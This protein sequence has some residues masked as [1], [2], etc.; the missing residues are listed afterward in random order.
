[1]TKTLETQ[2]NIAAPA[3]TVWAVLDNIAA[4]GAWNSLV[5]ELAGQ[6]MVGRQ[7]TGTLTREGLPTVPLKPTITAVVAAREFRWLS[8]RPVP[9]EF[10]AEHYFLLEPNPDGT[11]TLHHN[12][13]FAG[14]FLAVVWDGINGLGRVAYEKMNAEM[15]ARAEAFAN[16]QPAL[17]PAVD[18]P[19]PES[20]DRLQGATLRCACATDPVEVSLGAGTSHNHL[21]GCSKCWRPDGAL[22]AQIA[23][24]PAGKATVTAHGDKLAPVDPNQKIVRHACNSCGTHMIGRVSDPDHHFFGLDFVHPELAVNRTAAAPEF[25]GFV[26]S[27]IESGTDPA[28]MVAIRKQLSAR[29]LPAYDGFSPEMMDVIAWHRVKLGRRTA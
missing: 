22:F 23:V 14:T 2:I 28:G 13:D 19:R 12:E 8:E 1:M 15:K 24:L 6:T 9:G 7:L 27:L 10:R 25:A 26:S 4:Y 17:H 18:Q 5:P 16:E 11:T 29:D 21:C 20:Q 3:Q